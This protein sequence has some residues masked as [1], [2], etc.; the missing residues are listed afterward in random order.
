VSIARALLKDAPI[1]VLDEATAS[2]DAEAD[3]AVQTAVAALSRRATLLVIAHRLQTVQAADQILVLSDGRIS[4]RGS[5][6]ELIDR[7]GLYASFWRERVE[8]Q[9]WRLVDA[10][11]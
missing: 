6:D 4:D 7:P 9:G 11:R 3:A 10:D 2:L 5:H 8:A 1:V